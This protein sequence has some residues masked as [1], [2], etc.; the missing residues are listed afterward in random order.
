M[1]G[2]A[3]LD[4]NLNLS[5]NSRQFTFYTDDFG[6][7][8][9][10]WMDASR[11]IGRWTGNFSPLI[12]EWTEDDGNGGYFEYAQ[13]TMETSATTLFLTDGGTYGV[14][15]DGSQMMYD[16][17]SKLLLTQSGIWYDFSQAA[18]NLHN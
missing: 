15:D 7:N 10:A 16:Y 3:G 17:D 4:L 8:Y 14:A 5:Y 9:V 1:K 13:I 12:T 11:T 2:R 18:S 6:N